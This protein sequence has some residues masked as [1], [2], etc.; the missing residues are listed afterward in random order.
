MDAEVGDGV[1]SSSPASTTEV[2]VK[3]VPWWRRLPSLSGCGTGRKA[4][5]AASVAAAVLI[6]AVVLSYYARGDYDE[7]PSSL[8]T[9]TTATR[10]GRQWSHPA[11]EEV[12][13]KVVEPAVARHR[14]RSAV[15]QLDPRAWEAKQRSERRPE[16][17]G[18]EAVKGEVES[19][20]GGG[21]GRA[22]HS[23]GPDYLFVGSGAT[24]GCRTGYRWWR[25]WFTSRAPPAR[26]SPTRRKRGEDRRERGE[27]MGL[28]DAPPSNSNLTG[29]QLLGDLLSAAFSWQSCRSRHEALQVRCGPGTAPYEK[30]LRQLKSGD[31]AIAADGDDDDC[32][33]VVSMVYDRGL[34]NRVI[35]IISAFLYAVLTERALL[36]APYNG[37]VDAL[38]CEPFPGT[39]WIHPGGR[40]FPLRRLRDLD[41]KSRESL[42]TLLK[43]NAV[44]VDAGGNGTSSWS[45]RPPPYVYLHL[46][47]GADYHDKLFYCDEQQRLLRG[48]PWLLM[49]TDSYLVP[50]LFIVPSLRGELERMFP[51]KD[52]VFHHLSRYLLHPAN[53]LWHAI[54]PCSTTSPAPATSSAYRF[55]C[56]TRRRRRDD[57]EHVVVGPGRARDVA[58]L[59][60]LAGE[61]PWLMPR[62]PVW[63][64]EPATEVPEP[65]C[66][67]AASPEPCFHSPS[68]YDCAARRNY[69]DIGKAVPYIRRCED[70]SWGIQLVKGSSHW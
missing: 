20:D 57:D 45:G 5:R 42:G 13:P 41:G 23:L 32:R 37:D 46:D 11:V 56:T 44:S 55:A 38:F 4:V 62:R 2:A 31:G 14:G 39:T 33:Y 29:D 7:M 68:Y 17:C 19:P 64:K 52:A 24:R 22:S 10:G 15:P 34:G 70:V 69:E 35:P 30:A 58:E 9:T 61:R 25:K 49:K 36:V 47:G 66:V 21:G 27:M 43:S 26:Q 53:A 54:T 1:P 18:K 60:G 3:A 6:A 65:P 59:V 50:G 63:D 48:T 28:E 12:E 8:F 51:E 40:R 67:R 16:P